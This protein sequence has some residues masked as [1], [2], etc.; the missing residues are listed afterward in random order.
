MQELR[1][2]RWAPFVQLLPI[3]SSCPVSECD[4]RSRCCTH[5]GL[6]WHAHTVATPVCKACTDFHLQSCP[7]A[8]VALCLC[9]CCVSQAWVVTLHVRAGLR[10]ILM[11]VGVAGCKKHL[12][13]HHLQDSAL[14]GIDVSMP[15]CLRA[16][17]SDAM[18][19]IMYAF[20]T[21]LKQ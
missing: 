20:L 12:F 1:L 14:Y 18:L 13:F 11:A 21:D 19:Q 8:H 16:F 7:L 5:L 4:S 15:V 9:T 2:R 17:T 6:C 3:C 10:S